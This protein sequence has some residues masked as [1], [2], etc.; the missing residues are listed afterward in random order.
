ML[1]LN[2]KNLDVWQL[3]VKFVSFIYEITSK[4]PKDELFGLANQTRRAAVSISANIA[5]GSS[6]K[7]LIERKRFY[8]IARSSLVEVD[9]HLEIAIVL[10]YLDEKTIN[11]I[12]EKLN[13]L[14]AKLSKFIEKVK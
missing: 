8:E 9:N 5:E 12:S 4:Y 2:H 6:R 7:S 11:E 13:E 1:R 3:A 14:F 10:N